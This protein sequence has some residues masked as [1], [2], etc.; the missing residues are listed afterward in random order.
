MSKT[1][2]PRADPLDPR[3]KGVGGWLLFLVVSLTLLSPLISLSGILE[4][5]EYWTHYFNRAP[6]LAVIVRITNTIGYCLIAFC[7][8]AGI[9]LWNLRPNAVRIAKL[10]LITFFVVSI[11]LPFLPL[12]INLP[13][14]LHDKVL[15]Q[16]W[17]GLPTQL[18]FPVV[19]YSYLTFSKR[20]AATYGANK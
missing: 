6:G 16:A 15:E 11:V 10:F 19:W 12:M 18:I 14:S 9:S 2:E 7:V 5:S 4:N 8:Y 20:V 13:E 17:Y 3:Y 1:H